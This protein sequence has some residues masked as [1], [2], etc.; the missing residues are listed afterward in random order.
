MT[1]APVISLVR[2]LT[3]LAGS[4]PIS[5][6]SCLELDI[7]IPA[8]ANKTAPQQASGQV[9]V[10]PPAGGKLDASLSSAW[11]RSPR[12]TALSPG[13]HRG[14]EVSVTRVANG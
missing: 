14:Y 10:C 3:A 9:A 8:L 5:D 12:A 13:H 7:G 2:T 6:P 11:P 1:G 4:S